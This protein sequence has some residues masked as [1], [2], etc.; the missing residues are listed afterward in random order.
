MYSDASRRA[1]L[2]PQKQPHLQAQMWYDIWMPRQHSPK[3][4]HKLVKRL[5]AEGRPVV[6][7][8][9]WRYLCG[10]L[11]E[12]PIDTPMDDIL[13]EAK[14]AVEFAQS[15][16]KAHARKSKKGTKRREKDIQVAL[17]RLKT[18]MKPVRHQM[19][20][21]PYLPETVD[22]KGI[23]EASASL[24][25]ERRKLWKMRTNAKN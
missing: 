23:R 20:R 2:L 8:Y 19:S 22:K 15:V 3:R 25:R 13:T 17:D 16:R 4:A 10:T 12:M 6:F 11:Y 9:P 24:Q 14:R 7:A 5:E 1:K 18:A 21:M